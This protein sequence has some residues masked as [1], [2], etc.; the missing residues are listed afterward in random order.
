MDEHQLRQWTSWHRWVTLAMLAHAFLT[1]VRA[2]EHAR[3]PKPDGRIPLP[4]N[5]IQRLFIALVVRTVHGTA[6]R[7]D[8][9]HWRRHH[10]AQ[11]QASHY[12]RQATQT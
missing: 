6:H 3:H 5:E 2:D 12:R 9:S 10:Q 11:S 8:W 7:L 4:R 1:V